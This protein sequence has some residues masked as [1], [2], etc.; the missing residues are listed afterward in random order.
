MQLLK[1]PKIF[2][3]NRSLALIDKCLMR[4][5][6]CTGALL[7]TAR[8]SGEARLRRYHLPAY[9]QASKYAA[10]HSQY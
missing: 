4:E 9:I 8:P 6:V 3:W 1:A 7:L 10:C 5:S 2:D